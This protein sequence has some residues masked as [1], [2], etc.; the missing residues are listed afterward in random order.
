MI[1]LE[2]LAE[3]VAS[4]LRE[5][6]RRVIL[7]EDVA[8]GGL[9]GLTRVAA[10]DESLAGRLLGAPLSP[11]TTLVH[12][13]GLALAGMRPCVI[14]GSAMSLLEGLAGLREAARLEWR[15]GTR[16][17]LLVIAPYGPGFGLGEDAGDGLEGLLAAMPGL[18]TLVLGR[19]HEG[20]AVLRAAAEF[21]GGERPTV[22]LIPRAL[23]LATLDPADAVTQLER[24]FGALVPVRRGSQAVVFTWG[25]S[26]E[27]C[28]HAIEESGLD[29][30]LVQLE[31]LGH[32]PR[33]S[34][35]ELAQSVGRIVIVH[36]GPQAMGVGAELAATLA[37]GAVLSL[38]AP[39]VRVTGQSGPVL[40][41]EEHRAVPDPAAIRAAIEYVVTY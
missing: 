19:R 12:A 6:E 24:P 26:V 35:L 25:A 20:S 33:G 7:G 8:D 28:E 15:L 11:V 40:P 39:I 29:V 36:H 14:V 9:L 3:T 4:L 41:L 22:L 34:I 30:T 5:D 21:R 1:V 2:H 13:A 31:S 32:L 37:D 16:I 10:A 17:P 18:Q 27:V 23:G 38:D